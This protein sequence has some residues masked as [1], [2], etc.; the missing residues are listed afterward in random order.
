MIW[1]P[2]IKKQMCVGAKQ[3]Q[4]NV[5]IF[6]VVQFILQFQQLLIYDLTQRMERYTARDIYP[7]NKLM[8]LNFKK[9]FI[10]WSSANVFV[11]IVSLQN[12]R[13]A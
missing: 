12:Y 11:S 6:P 9:R 10:F 3:Q 4:T 1:L 7:K 2:I 8:L 5:H 13:Y